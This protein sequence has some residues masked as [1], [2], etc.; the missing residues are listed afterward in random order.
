MKQLAST[1]Y[2]IGAAWFKVFDVDSP[3]RRANR[4]LIDGNHQPYQEFIRFFTE[5]NQEIKRNLNIEQ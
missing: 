5:T 1:P 3:T 2:V 4:G